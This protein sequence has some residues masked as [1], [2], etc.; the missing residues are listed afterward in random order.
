MAL[1]DGEVF[2]GYRIQRQLGAGGMGEVY[3]AQHPRLPRLD[4]LKILPAHL[5]ED[6]AFR[7]RFLREADLAATLWHQHIV[8][9]H[10]R[11]EHDGQLWI[12]M[13]F[14]DGTD[15]ARYL[16]AAG[17][18]GL[19]LDLVLA[20]T[21][22]VSDAL[23]LAHQRELLHRDVK[24][25]NILLTTPN[26]GRQRILLA[27][28]GIARQAHDTH[29]LTE[30]NMTVGT[31]SYAAPEQLLGE[32]MTG[33][34]D[35]YALAASVFTL[36]T[37][38]PPFTATNPAVVISKHL[39]SAPPALSAARPELR[40]LDAVIA[41]A[42]SKS[43]SDRYATCQDF[44]SALRQAAIAASRPA[45][46]S[47]APPV[48]ALPASAHDA[49]TQLA[50][51][52][53]AVEHTVHARPASDGIATVNRPAGV[54]GGA[55]ANPA[56]SVPPPRR[57]LRA[58]TVAPAILGLLTVVAVAVMIVEHSIRNDRAQAAPQWQPFLDTASSTAQ[59]LTTV[60]HRTAQ[61]D[62][63]RIL[64][65]ATGAFRDDFAQRRQPFIDSVREAQSVSVGTVTA[66][67]LESFTDGE[68]AKVLVA[69]TVETT[70]GSE[71]KQEPK[72]WRMRVTVVREQT[73]FKTQDVEFVS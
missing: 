64:D 22:A 37:G 12:S 23:D 5:T 53:P 17:T 69:V 29:G 61:A 55:E 44:A 71:P 3:L 26:R 31:V 15:A 11:G 60:D 66:S 45:T 14:V 7:Q 30:T 62:T 72:L 9:V 41:R 38:G 32:D 1:S 8:G 42:L 28:F 70:K 35:Q 51:S 57:L 16:D 56:H 73:D 39:S 59:A 48:V 40:A 54:I 52:S 10:D 25:A 34:A 67:A 24:P 18:P 13:D 2:A 6:A 36:L 50:R 19:P 49:P 63:Q 4:A 65:G 21:D 47:P 58:T 43:P 20:V 33:A 68:R 46:T 27:D